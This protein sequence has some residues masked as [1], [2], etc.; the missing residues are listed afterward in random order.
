M[1]VAELYT[2]HNKFF[3]P[4]LMKLFLNKSDVFREFYAVQRKL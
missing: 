4:S 3:C 2:L 1:G